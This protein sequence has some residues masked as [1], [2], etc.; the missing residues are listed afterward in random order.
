MTQRSALVLTVFFLCATAPF[1]LAEPADEFPGLLLDDMRSALEEGAGNR[2][3]GDYFLGDWA[4]LRP[5]LASRGIKPRVLLITDPFGNVTGG[6]KQ[7]FTTYSLLCVDLNLD[8]EKLARLPGGEFDIGFALN[9]GNSLS[10]DDVGNSFPIQLADVAPVG[11]RLTYL[12][13]TQKFFDDKLSLRAGRLTINSV[14]SEEFAAS[15]YFTAFSSVAFN[16]VPIGIFLNAPG[17]FGYPLTTWGARAKFEPN[18]S[19]YTM[20]GIYNGDP[21]VGDANRYGLDFTFKGPPFLIAEAGYRYTARIFSEALPGNLKIG[22]YFNGGR[23]A[24]FGSSSTTGGIHGF[25]AIADQMLVRW[26]TPGEQR[27]LGIFAAT[28]VAPDQR[29]SPMPFFFDA[30]VVAYGP[31]A[32]RPKDFI[33][34]GAAYGAYSSNLQ[35][36]QEA[37]STAVQ[38]EEMTVELSYG[39][40][41]A[42]GLTLQP[43]L[44]YIVHPGGDRSVPN[45]LAIGVN[46]TVSF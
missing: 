4:G 6:Q 8:M 22:G 9:T 16:L 37:N 38:N 34:L 24:E 13:Y 23:T 14:Y 10:K 26:G 31:L 7:G 40:R 42:P 44:Q 2:Y 3:T 41:I 28:V 35:S 21:A 25:Y 15:Q 29:V 36:A 30:G 18:K 45:A 46:V 33:A 11:P 19:F 5:L 12:S 17:A 1:C 20:V 43:A 39:C 27:H 32:S